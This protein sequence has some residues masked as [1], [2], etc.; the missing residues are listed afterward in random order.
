MHG[1]TDSRIAEEEEKLRLA[2]AIFAP[3]PGVEA[4]LEGT[5][6][7]SGGVISAS[8]GGYLKAER[9]SSRNQTDKPV[10]LFVGRLCIRKG[11][12]NLLRAWRGA[13][14]DGTLVLAGS[15]EPAVERICSDELNR[16]DVRCVGFV[17][18]VEALYRTADVFVLPSF[19]EGDPLVTYEAASHGL[20]I[21]ASTMG[22][23]RIGAETECVVLIDPS[24]PDTIT[25]ALRRLATSLELRREF[26]K[27]ALTA[28]RK[29]EWVDVGAARV[30][31]LSAA[32][33]RTSESA[34][35]V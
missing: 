11:V 17:R 9:P 34:N 30:A 23:G 25:A 5:G 35:A 6:L 15:I 2:R 13:K 29:Y 8:Y 3:S 4:S 1:I 22:A 20:P 28:I 7:A 21:V 19:E 33:E 24:D 14:V 31:K 32:L 16:S 27:A 12:H 18:D 10:F 26:G